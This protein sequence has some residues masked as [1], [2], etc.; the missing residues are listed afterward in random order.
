MRHGY[1][2]I[3]AIGALFVPA[4]AQAHPGPHRGEL[5][6]SLAHAVTQTDHLAAIG[7]GA[8]LALAAFWPLAARR[9]RA[10]AR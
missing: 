10:P 7:V 9:N 4:S 3:L 8:A 6:W 1:R 5:L 2:E